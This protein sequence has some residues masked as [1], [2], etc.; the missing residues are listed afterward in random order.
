MASIFSMNIPF[1]SFLIMGRILKKRSWFRYPAVLCLCNYI[2]LKVCALRHK[3]RPVRVFFGGVFSGGTLNTPCMVEQQ[4]FKPW[5]SA[6]Q[7]Q[8]S[9][10]LSYCPIRKN[11]NKKQKKCQ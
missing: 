11:F 3:K 9:N 2:I 10:Q 6:L 5:T 8:R 7:R 4:G 1:L